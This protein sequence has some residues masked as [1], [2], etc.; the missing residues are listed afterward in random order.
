MSLV[1]LFKRF[2]KNLFF[3]KPLGTSYC[4]WWKSCLAAEVLKVFAVLTDSN[5][6]RLEKHFCWSHSVDNL[7]A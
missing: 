5:K 7:L 3:P 4:L 1:S 2:L 6:T